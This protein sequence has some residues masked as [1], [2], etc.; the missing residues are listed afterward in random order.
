MSTILDL[1][2]AA[3]AAASRPTPITQ[4][5]Q[6]KLAWMEYAAT[7][8]RP[9]PVEM[10]RIGCD[11]LSLRPALLPETLAV[12][13]RVPDLAQPEKGA[14][15][16]KRKRRNRRPPRETHPLTPA[17][18]EALRLVGD[19]QGNFTK[20]ARAA[21]KSRTAIKKLYDKVMK[22]LGR[23]ASKALKSNTRPLPLDGRGQ[24]NIP[25]EDEDE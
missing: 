18:T 23:S 13:L 8:R 19:H 6:A 11:V 1:I 17:Q 2:E 21:G 22:K 10:A 25:A 12:P 14:A 7:G 24:A 9:P 16:K 4:Y 3:Q 5:L 20:A 15:T